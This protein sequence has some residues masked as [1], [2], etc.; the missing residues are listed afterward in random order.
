MLTGIWRSILKVISDKITVIDGLHDVPAPNSSDN[1]FIRDVLGNKSDKNLLGPGASSLYQLAGYMAYYHVH[2]PSLV[3]PRDNDPELITAG[4]GAWT[5]GLKVEIIASGV[6]SNPFDMHFVI[7]GAISQVDDY[8]IKLYIGDSGQEVFWGEC[9][10]SRDTNQMRA[11]FV[12]IQGPPI[13]AGTRIS[14]S[15]LSGN[16]SNTTAIK[17]YT[18]EYP[19]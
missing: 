13:A 16:G 19:G 11:A 10:Y 1:N 5:E 15:L 17:I 14:A 4:L 2:N 7:L 8:V 3:Y 6:K 9:A 12:P 18:H